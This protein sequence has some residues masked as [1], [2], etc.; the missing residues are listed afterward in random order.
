MFQIMLTYSGFIT[1]ILKSIKKE[2]HFLVIVLIS[3]M[4][5]MDDINLY[6]YKLLVYLIILRL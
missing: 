3:N 6:K 1:V 4:V 5:N 2:R